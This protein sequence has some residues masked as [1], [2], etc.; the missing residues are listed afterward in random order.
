MKTHYL[1]LFL[2]AC[3]LP[4][5]CIAASE[6]PFEGP[7]A[8]VEVAYEDYG[9]DVDGET[10]AI[11]AGWDFKLGEKAVLGLDARYKVHGIDTSRTSI[12]PAGF[13]QTADVAID[14]NWG[15]A[16]RIG[17]AVSDEVLLFAAAGYEK[18]D[19][20]ALRTVRSRP[21]ATPT[22]CV[23]SRTDFS[24]KD[25][26]WTLGVGAEWAA[27]R[28]VRLRAQYTY[29]ESDSYDRNRFSLAAAFQF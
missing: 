28:N 15:F 9:S 11:V 12:T 3:A 7:R 26:M 21:C 29:G 4:A 16:G 17:Y 10:V 6:H 27:T 1:A 19:I 20:E 23:V 18:I 22:G 25:D 2:P 5:P 24:L 13:E 8:G 14:Q